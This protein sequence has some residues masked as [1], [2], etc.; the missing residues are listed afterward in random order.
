[1]HFSD[2]RDVH[3]MKPSYLRGEIPADSQYKGT[4]ARTLHWIALPYFSVEPYSGFEAGAG[5]ASA[6]PAPTLLQSQFSHVAKSRDP[7]QAVFGIGNNLQQEVCL[8]V[9]QLWCLIF[10]NALIVTY[11]NLP[12][13][14]F[15]GDYVINTTGHWTFSRGFHEPRRLWSVLELVSCGRYRYM[16]ARHGLL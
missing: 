7:R 8:H 5:S 9:P 1:M 14:Y 6:V 3:R 15:P 4:Q 2:G 16:N 13:K 11:I 10:D 12:D